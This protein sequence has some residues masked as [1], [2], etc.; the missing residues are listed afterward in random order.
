MAIFRDQN[1]FK[2]CI[3]LK[4]LEVKL[5]RV[6]PIFLNQIFYSRAC[7][8]IILY[9][10][11]YLCAGAERTRP[12]FCSGGLNSGA[13]ESLRLRLIAR[14]AV[15]RKFTRRAL[16]ESCGV[17]GALIGIGSGL[18]G[19]R[20]LSRAGVMG[21]SRSEIGAGDGGSDSTALAR[22]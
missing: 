11:L 13:L 16:A 9:Y 12:F 19:S 22:H 2:I 6:F 8:I 20:G 3:A 5:V 10:N 18:I 4:I 14:N 15:L 21:R 17:A 1:Y 7:R